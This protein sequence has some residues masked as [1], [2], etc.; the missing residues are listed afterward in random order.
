MN[1]QNKKHNCKNEQN[2]NTKENR[3]EQNKNCR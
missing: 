1:N 3:G 2:Q